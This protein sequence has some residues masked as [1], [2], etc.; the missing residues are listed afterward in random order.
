VIPSSEGICGM[1][2]KLMIDYAFGYVEDIIFYVNDTNIRSQKA[3]QK[4][5]GIRITDARYK[6]LLKED[7]EIW[8][9][10]INNKAK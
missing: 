3:V 8:T 2:K 7:R 1:M 10:R 5:G 4:I 9:Y 6:H